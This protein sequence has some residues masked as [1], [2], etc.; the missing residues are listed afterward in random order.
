MNT[1]TQLMLQRRSRRRFSPT[2]VSEAQI[3]EV[4]RAA[5]AAPTAKNVQPWHFVI[6]R[7]AQTLAR[8]AAQLPYAKMLAGASLAI[9]VCGD[10]E[11]HT[12]PG[13]INWVVDCAAATENLLLALEAQGLAA[14]WT[15]A[16]PYEDRMAVLRE[17]LGLP[18][19][20]VP[21]NIIPIGGIADDAPALDKWKPERIHKER[22]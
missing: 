20:I 5:M 18:E 22:W 14:V 2:E 7:D 10:T 1:Y 16:Y 21:L 13:A 11:A 15:A 17:N 8:M 4:L 19:H 6:I 12:G 3:E 9:A